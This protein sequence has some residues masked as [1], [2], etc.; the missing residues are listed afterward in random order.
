M[1]DQDS[2]SKFNLFDGDYS[3]IKNDLVDDDFYNKPYFN[4]ALCSNED[5]NEHR[6][7]GVS[8]FNGVIVVKEE[9]STLKERFEKRYNT[10][11]NTE[12]FK[13][14]NSIIKKINLV[15]KFWKNKNPLPFIYLNFILFQKM[16]LVGKGLYRMDKC[17]QS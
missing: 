14:G 4:L 17:Y 15:R 1:I 7:V 16:I 13:L 5:N 10:I 3:H 8:F 11:L 12:S 9:I 6:E 2:E